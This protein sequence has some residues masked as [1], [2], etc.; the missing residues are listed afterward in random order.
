MYED[1]RNIL[2]EHLSAKTR[3]P[4][5]DKLRQRA[6]Q[7]L[8]T[9]E[10]GIDRVIRRAP[11]FRKWHKYL[12]EIRTEPPGEKY[13]VASFKGWTRA[14]KQEIRKLVLKFGIGRFEK[15]QL[16]LPHKSVSMI[17]GYIQQQLGRLDLEE[18]GGEH[19]DIEKVRKSKEK[20]S[21]MD[22]RCI[23]RFSDCEQALVL[24][25][26]EITKEFAPEYAA[27]L[28]KHR[29]RAAD[30]VR[31]AAELCRKLAVYEKMIST[32]VVAFE[33]NEEAEWEANGFRIRYERHEEPTRT[34]RVLTNIPF[35]IEQDSKWRYL[36]SYGGKIQLTAIQCAGRVFEILFDESEVVL[37]CCIA[38]P[39]KVWYALDPYNKNWCQGALD[40]PEVTL[41][42]ADPPWRGAEDIPGGD[43]NWMNFGIREVRPHYVA[44]WIPQG[45]LCSAFQYMD[46]SE[47]DPVH[48]WVWVK[49]TPRE[50]IRGALGRLFQRSHEVLYFFKRRGLEGSVEVEEVKK[51]EVIL[52]D[53]ADFG[54][55]PLTVKKEIKR[56]MGDNAVLIELFSS[57]CG[58]QKGW[59]HV[60][61]R[62]DLNENMRSLG[63]QAVLRQSGVSH[64]W[65]EGDV[66][67]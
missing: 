58:L 49:M 62:T 32:M 33:Q 37:K 2:T 27:E 5:Q 43:P 44:V 15:Y 22:F 61:T 52:A 56:I 25:N 40:L 57:I 29:K 19:W 9:V 36:I 16:Y 13:E 39:E 21:S 64:L 59:L 41:I 38:P 48:S 54:I 6:R 46:K 50:K 20:I 67:L 12:S 30:Y 42:L 66:S 7:T 8:V 1:V 24:S 23:R 10:H 47:Y 11:N 14:E 26:E 17:R 18:I 65:E 53:R 35:Q 45:R 63:V 3:R 4:S 51:R 28:R 55:K 31:A 34:P 60:G